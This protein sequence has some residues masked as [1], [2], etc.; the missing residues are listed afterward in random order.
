MTTQKKVVITLMG[1]LVILVIVLGVTLHWPVWIIDVTVL[2]GV[3]VAIV[4]VAR[5]PRQPALPDFEPPPPP[6]EEPLPPPVQMTVVQGVN[7][8]S[9]WPDY[10]FLF[11]VTVYWRMVEGAPASPHVRPGATAVEMIIRRAAD[12]ARRQVP[13]MAVQL[14]HHLDDVLG[15]VETDPSG[16]VMVWADQVRMTVPDRDLVRLREMSDIRKDRALWQHK[17]SRE[18]D[19]REYLTEDVLKDAGSALVWWLSRNEA[20]VTR[21]VDLIGPMARLSAAARNEAPPDPL[22][23]GD[24]TQSTDLLYGNGN[25]H[26]TT[27]QAAAAQLMDSLH[28]DPDQQSWF[29]EGMAKT[30]AAMGRDTEAQQIR[31][32]FDAYPERFTDAGEPAVDEEPIGLTRYELAEPAPEPDGVQGSW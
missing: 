16:R 9:A 4:T 15:R 11:D 22:P 23:T 27:P 31:E 29:A 21:A 32:R 17:R 12:V 10:E 24:L 30:L 28:M 26:G 8:P 18:S 13:G 2:A 25:G 3:V 1:V 5:R 20:N 19:L 7:L 14:R 6:E